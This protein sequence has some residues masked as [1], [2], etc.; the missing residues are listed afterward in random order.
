MSLAGE[1][2]K[3][4]LDAGSRALLDA[5]RYV[6]RVRRK[7][8]PR[9]PQNELRGKDVIHIHNTIASGARAFPKKP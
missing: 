4:A 3:I 8:G 6:F 2:A 9:K 1:L 5:A 7:P